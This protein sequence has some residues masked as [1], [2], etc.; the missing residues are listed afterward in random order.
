MQDFEV[1]VSPTAAREIRNIVFFIANEQCEPE[2]A[3]KWAESLR[4]AMEKLA[5]FPERY[6]ETPTLDASLRST[7]KMP[8]GS[9]LVFYRIHPVKHTVDIAHVLHD[10][11]NWKK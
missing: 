6:P 2:A 5:Q 11:T 1:I 4:D 7:R 9:Y 3:R 8:V 10:R